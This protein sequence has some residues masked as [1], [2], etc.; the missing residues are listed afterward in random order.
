MLEEPSDQ[1]APN[2]LA[3]PLTAT[4]PRASSVSE[5]REAI[6]APASTA[7]VAAPLAA[8]PTLRSG[9]SQFRSDTANSAA[10][11]LPGDDNV[12]DCIVGSLES[13]VP[14]AAEVVCS[15]APLCT[16]TD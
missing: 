9:T 14:L 6:A 10:L 11:S 4:P 5:P 3:V 12:T 13:A 2:P 7:T 8:V 15:V 1:A 16:S